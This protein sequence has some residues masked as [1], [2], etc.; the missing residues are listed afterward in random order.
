MYQPDDAHDL[1]HSIAIDLTNGKTYPR[2]GLYGALGNYVA[3]ATMSSMDDSLAKLTLTTPGS[4]APLGTLTLGDNGMIYAIP[5]STNPSLV[6]PGA[7]FPTNDLSSPISAAITP[8]GSVLIGLRGNYAQDAT[9]PRWRT[10]SR[11]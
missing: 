7:Q 5:P 2:P 3:A 11:R 10:R 9:P 4:W 6:L 8:D 1:S